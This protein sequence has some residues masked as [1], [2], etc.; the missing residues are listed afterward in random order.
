MSQ[1]SRQGLYVY[2]PFG[3]QDGERWHAGRI[4]GVGGLTPL[5]RCDGFTK[6]EA[7]AIVAALSA[8]AP[9][10]V[11]QLTELR[12]ELRA[13]GIWMT[14]GNGEDVHAIQSDDVMRL[15]DARLSR[16]QADQEGK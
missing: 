16:L 2:Q 10:A 1:Q 15:I 14:A 8:P 11:H 9:S 6:V 7:T 3:V 5:S 4:Y 13:E 12:A